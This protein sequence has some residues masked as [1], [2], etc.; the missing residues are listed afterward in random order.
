MTETELRPIDT[1]DPDVQKLAVIEIAWQR[2]IPWS[3]I[4]AT[5]GLRDKRAAKRMRNDLDKRIRLK[6]Q[7]NV[8]QQP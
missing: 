7:T 2:G 1:N 3:A 8:G 5:L 6:Q 4:A